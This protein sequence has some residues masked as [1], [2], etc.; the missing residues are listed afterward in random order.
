[1][2]NNL[3]VIIFPV[4]SAWTDRII[5]WQKLKFKMR[6]Q[7]FKCEGTSSCRHLLHSLSKHKW[8]RRR[9]DYR[10][11]KLSVIWFYFSKGHVGWATSQA[12]WYN[13]ERENCC[14]GSRSSIETT[15]TRSVKSVWQQSTKRWTISSK[16]F[17]WQMQPLQKRSQKT[18]LY[19]PSTAAS[20]TGTAATTKC[21]CCQRWKWKWLSFKCACIYYCGW[22][23]RASGWRRR[24][25]NLVWRIRETH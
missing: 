7:K 9:E 11:T 25:F 17:G 24:Q 15:L 8:C 2:I 22:L 4:G 23:T 18:W 5:K 19:K 1:M 20:T 14:I 10:P 13:Q 12:K 6:K 16:P 3:D 21:K